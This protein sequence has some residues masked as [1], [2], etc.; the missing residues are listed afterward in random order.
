MTGETELFGEAK[1]D[2]VVIAEA[3]PRWND[4]F[5]YYKSKLEEALGST[6][7]RID[8]VG[9]TAVAGLPAKP[10]IDIQVSVDDVTEEESYRPAIE[11]L[12]W[13]LRARELDHRFFR[14]PASEERSVHVHVCSAGSD[15]ERRHL[16]FVAYL[17]ANSERSAQYAEVKRELAQ[18]FG[19]KRVAYT[20][21]KDHFIDETLRLA[22]DWA[23][24][25]GW[26]P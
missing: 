17:S 5:E 14:P 10:V 6:A 8:H 25:T 23:V 12:G 19:T 2:P 18:R 11:S 16:L 3:D 20:D 24:H 4:L 22:D 26:L 7:I 13:P 9:S 1:R 15:W 21:A